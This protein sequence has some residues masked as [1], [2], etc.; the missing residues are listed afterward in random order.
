[1]FYGIYLLFKCVV[2]HQVNLFAHCKHGSGVGVRTR[3]E[4]TQANKYSWYCSL[5][6]RLQTQDV[7]GKKIQIK[8]V[9]H[10]EICLHH[11]SCLDPSTQGASVP[12]NCNTWGPCV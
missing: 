12:K 5:W 8:E 4:Q 11:R 7:V 9:Y 1:M 6:P 10:T 2:M 3:I